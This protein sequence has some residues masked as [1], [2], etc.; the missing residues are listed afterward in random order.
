[1]KYYYIDEDICILGQKQPP[2]KIVCHDIT[3]RNGKAYFFDENG[4][5]YT[6]P[7]KDII[8]E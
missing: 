1:M 2:Q 5:D 3:F 8:K 4:N 6:V 7:E